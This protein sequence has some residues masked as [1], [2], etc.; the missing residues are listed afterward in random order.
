MLQI[1]FD[2]LN[3]SDVMLSEIIQKSDCNLILKQ[4]NHPPSCNINRL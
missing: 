2:L 1:K 3:L 4:T